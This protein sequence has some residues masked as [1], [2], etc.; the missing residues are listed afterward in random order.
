MPADTMEPEPAETV[1]DGRAS[2]VGEPPE[3]M[4]P[5]DEDLAYE[6]EQREDEPEEQ[7]EEAFE[8]IDLMDLLRQNAEELEVSSPIEMMEIYGETVLEITFEELVQY[9][10]HI[11]RGNR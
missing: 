11:R 5:A 1:E 4:E 10:N 2:D 7:P 3:E 9:N 8:G 6:Q